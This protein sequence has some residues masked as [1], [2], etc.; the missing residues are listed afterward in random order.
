MTQKKVFDYD[1][2]EEKIPKKRKTRM[3]K[4]EGMEMGLEGEPD[5]YYKKFD[6]FYKR[7]CFRLMVEFYKLLFAPYH[8]KWVDQRK[9]TDMGNYIL[10]FATYYFGNL[11]EKLPKVY[12]E[13]FIAGLMV[14]VNSHRHN[15]ED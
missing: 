9:K 10:A 12:Q 2:E 3:K 11:L 14:V 6:F 5:K 7:T 1:I 4:P 15:K 8:K 13:Q